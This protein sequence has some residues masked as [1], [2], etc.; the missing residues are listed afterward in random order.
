MLVFQAIVF[1]RSSFAF[2]PASLSF[3]LRF[4]YASLLFQLSFGSFIAQNH[5]IKSDLSEVNKTVSESRGEA[6]RAPQNSGKV[7][8]IPP[9]IAAP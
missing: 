3:H 7:S 9:G 4:T 5:P 6:D 2:A 1:F 8:I